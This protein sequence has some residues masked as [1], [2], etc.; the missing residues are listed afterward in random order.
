MAYKVRIRTNTSGWIRNIQSVSPRIQSYIGYLYTKWLVK[1][2]RVSTRFRS[3][4]GVFKVRKFLNNKAKKQ[5][6]KDLKGESV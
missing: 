1:T 4:D 6:I 5:A 3:N 2:G